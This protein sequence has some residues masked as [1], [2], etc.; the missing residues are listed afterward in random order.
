[1]QLHKSNSQQP[2]EGVTN[3]DG[4]I[5]F[6]VKD[7]CTVVVTVQK[8]GYSNLARKFEITHGLYQQAINKEI[9]LSLPMVKESDPEHALAY[10]VLSYAGL[11]RKIQLKALSC[12]GEEL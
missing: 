11:A 10:G 6:A 8:T 12:S 9:S 3:K 4:L 1:M 5:E 2:E 7:I